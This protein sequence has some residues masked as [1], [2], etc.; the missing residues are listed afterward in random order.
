MRAERD[1]QPCEKSPEGWFS[2]N[3]SS[4]PDL[5]DAP[6]ALLA[7]KGSCRKAV[8]KKHTSSV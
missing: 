3:A 6:T 2:E 4:L 1:N 5:G 7:V 8:P